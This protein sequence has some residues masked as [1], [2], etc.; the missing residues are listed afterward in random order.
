MLIT[1]AVWLIAG[2][3]GWGYGLI[4]FRPESGQDDFTLMAPESVAIRLYFGL[5]LVSFALLAA[6]LVTNISWWLGLALAVP[7]IVIAAKRLSH[8][9]PRAV[10]GDPILVNCFYLASGLLIL[11]YFVSTAEVQ[12]FDTGLYHQQM[13]KWLSDYGLV[14]GVALIHLCLGLTSSWF[15]AAATLNHGPLRG[16]EAAIIGGLPFALMLMSSAAVGWRYRLAGVLPGLRGLTWSLFC[17]M[18]LVISL[19]W[20]V[21]SSLSPEPLTWLLPAAIALVLSEP[22]TSKSD[23]IGLALLLSSLAFAVKLSAAPVIAYCGLLWLWR[24][25]RIRSERK[26]LLVYLALAS[27][28]VL[29]LAVANIRTSGCPLYPSPL[30]CGSGESSVGGAFAAALGRGVREFAVRGNRHVGWFVTA[31][32]AG[33]SFALK[34]AR[35]DPFILHGLAA[36][37]GGSVF[38]LMTAPNPRF[39]MGCLLLPVAMSLAIFVQSINRR[40][41]TVVAVG[42]RSLPWVTAAAV[43]VLLFLSIRE[44]DSPLSLWLPKR[45]ASAVGEPIHI[46]NQNLNKRTALSLTESK[47]GDV[48]V[49]RP[50][51]SDQCWDADLPCA[52]EIWR[53]LELREPAQGLQGGFRQSSSAL[54]PTNVAA[55]H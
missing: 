19:T 42:R 5:L 13:A 20:S 12:F 45:M 31:A 6:A 50:Q 41:S 7:G 38:I 34:T 55:G 54:P 43:L 37:W 10:P 11:A 53:N 21:E 47:F 52:G 29:V 30:G 23:R 49:L 51:S 33:T 36:S 17:G 28:V 14:R 35:K 27:M 26:A 18:L 24:F 44:A 46:V 40:C 8:A 15:A 4:C 2:F 16:R 48:T 3:A 25:A 1:F 39:G 9:C 32:L 22:S